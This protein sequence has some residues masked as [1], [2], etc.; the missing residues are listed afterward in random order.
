MRGTK[1]KKVVSSNT[2]IN[3]LSVATV[4]STTPYRP[5]TKTSSS[6]SPLTQTSSQSP[7]TSSKM[8]S[9]RIRSVWTSV[10][11][12]TSTM[13]PLRSSN[14]KSLCKSSSRRSLISSRPTIA[15]TPSARTRAAVRRRTYFL[16]TSTTLA[17]RTISLVTVSTC[18]ARRIRAPCSIRSRTWITWS[19]RSTWSVTSLRIYSFRAN[20]RNPL[21]WWTGTGM[22]ENLL[23]TL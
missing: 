3:K 2:R 15:L 21:R 16:T 1:N 19:S 4:T 13:R 17:S 20:L 5:S 12:E 11:R 7:R 10:T 6:L 8:V 9:T 14:N 22:G 18:K 23:R